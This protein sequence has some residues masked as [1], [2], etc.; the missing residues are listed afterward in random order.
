M[1]TLMCCRYRIMVE[2][3]GEQ[4]SYAAAPVSLEVGLDV[5]REDQL[6]LLLSDGAVRRLIRCVGDP[7]ADMVKVFTL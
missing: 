2:G 1:T 5:V 6:S 4:V 7:G 3:A